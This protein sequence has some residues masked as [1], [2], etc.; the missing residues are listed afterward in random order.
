MDDMQF[1]DGL[2]VTKTSDGEPAITWPLLEMGVEVC[3]HISEVANCPDL[4]PEACAS[5]VTQMALFLGHICDAGNGL[6]EM[7][8]RWR[9][10]AEEQ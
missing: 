10:H 5:A 8:E 9:L 4:A 2:L 3:L 1:V 6:V 7:P